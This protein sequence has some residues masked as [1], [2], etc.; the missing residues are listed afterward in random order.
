MQ[1]RRT[2]LVLLIATFIL[3]SLRITYASPNRV[4]PSI[5]V[6]ILVQENGNAT[7]YYNITG[8]GSGSF[9]I[10]LPKN[11][12]II[13]RT[14]EGE[15]S[16]INHTSSF[17]F[18]YNSTVNVKPS[19]N[20]RFS[21]QLKY[22]FPFASI[23]A[24]YNGWFMS[25]ALITEPRIKMTVFIRIPYLKR[26]TLE[27]PTHVGKKDGYLVY[28]LQGQMYAQLGGRITI[29]YDMSVPTQ[30]TKYSEKHDG[31]VVR[32]EYPVYYSSFAKKTV[33]IAAQA[34]PYFRDIFGVTPGLL[35]FRFYLPKRALG[36]IGTL[37]F[38]RGS[39]INVGG[40]GPIQLNL[41]LMRYA[42]GYHETTILHEM[43]HMYLGIIGVEANNNVRWFHE[44]MAEYVSME[45]AEKMGI[46][47]KDIKETLDNA[48]KQL[49]RQLGGN[50]G[51]IEEWPE[52]NEL[53][54]P[55]AYVASYYI[56]KYL[57]DK[58]GGLDYVSKVAKAIKNYGTIAS[59]Q[60]VVNVLS[61]A[62]GTDLSGLFRKWGFHDVKPWTGNKGEGEKT[63]G[64]EKK[65][66]KGEKQLLETSRSTLITI[67][68]VLAGTAAFLVYI[69]NARIT[70][71]VE[72]ALSSPIIPE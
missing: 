36:G 11:E 8:S 20:G 22:K 64:E 70:R 59:T 52:N 54:E 31:T 29:E 18:Y 5:N 42:P 9:W 39:D 35:E 55:Q 71:E 21:F 40:K 62:A 37:G 66:E 58:Y 3:S 24:D 10:F 61:E 27:E 45:I 25:P 23:M 33:R 6:Y 34:L 30:L 16:I 56:I 57:S 63:G 15:F 65:P 1:F 47:V 7:V 17:Y 60:D 13:G 32:I 49:Y 69:L 44:G 51:F 12:T 14:F 19:K 38:V 53:L 43:V 50:I 67:A 48:S 68:V 72:I 26:I 4:V 28:I 41:A 2:L 46:R